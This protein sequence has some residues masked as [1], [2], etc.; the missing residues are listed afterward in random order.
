MAVATVEQ[1]ALYGNDPGTELD[2]CWFK[3]YFERG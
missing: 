2:A 1:N 3:K